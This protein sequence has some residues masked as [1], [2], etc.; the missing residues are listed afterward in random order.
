MLYLALYNINY[1]LQVKTLYIIC[2]RISY[3]YDSQYYCKV[4]TLVDMEGSFLSVASLL[5]ENP[6]IV[7]LHGGS[8][9]KLLDGI[10]DTS[11]HDSP[12]TLK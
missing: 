7:H 4:D 1:Y 10:T 8:C 9:K 3:I 5:S 2:D 12:T 11:S 6:D